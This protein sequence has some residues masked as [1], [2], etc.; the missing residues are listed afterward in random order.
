MRIPDAI[1]PYASLLKWGLIV[2]VLFA[3]F[4]G[5]CSVQKN[6]DA[7]TIAEKN[8]ALTSAAVALRASGD[9]LRRQNEANAARIR[10]AEREAA[11]MAAGRKAA[12]SAREAG[13]KAHAAQRAA[14]ERA[15]AS[16]PSCAALLSTDL[17]KTCGVRPQ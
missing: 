6:R 9:A 15:G 5:G 17:F 12:E 13:E 16:R 2:A 10:E 11:Q 14:W 3:A 7:K 8:A 4:A 1:A